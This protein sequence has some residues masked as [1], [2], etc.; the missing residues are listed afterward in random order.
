MKFVY[1]KLIVTLTVSDDC[2]K[3]VLNVVSSI[4]IFSGESNFKKKLILTFIT[5]LTRHN[6]SISFL[7]YNIFKITRFIHF[8]KITVK[9]VKA[10]GKLN[11]YSYLILNVVNK[12]I[13]L[14]TLL[15][16]LRLH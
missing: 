13:F 3:C 8:I 6:F 2:L 16:Y 10:P 14:K 11:N 1:I 15:L 12:S 9:M 5:C 4:L 7:R